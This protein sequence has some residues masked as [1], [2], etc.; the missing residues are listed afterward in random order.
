MH[1]GAM[2]GMSTGENKNKAKN[3]PNDRPVDVFECVSMVKKCIMFTNMIVVCR[4]DQGE[5]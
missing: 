2:G 4:E 3:F 1:K 5:K